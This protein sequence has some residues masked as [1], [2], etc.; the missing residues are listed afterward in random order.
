MTRHGTAAA[1]SRDRGGEIPAS[2][3]GGNRRKPN[4]QR[5]SDH[6]SV[7]RLPWIDGEGC[8]ADYHA[9]QH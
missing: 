2:R 4:H 7:R 1:E 3:P 6:R 8:H 9:R 5:Y